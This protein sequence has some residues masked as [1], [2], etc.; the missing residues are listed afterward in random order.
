MKL[1]TYP[2]RDFLCLGLADL[3][4]SQLAE[5]LRREGRATLSVPGGTTPGPIF[6]TLSGVDMTGPMSRCAERRTLGAR[7]AAR[8]RT[9]GFCASGCCAGARR[10]RG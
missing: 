4:A 2:D 1:E 6:D 9:P 5:T 7:K 10:R 3:I 8:G